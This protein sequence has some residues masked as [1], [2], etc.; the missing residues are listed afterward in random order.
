MQQ[1]NIG[2]NS[3]VFDLLNKVK[4]N[5]NKTCI[6]EIMKAY[7]QYVDNTKENIDYSKF[8]TILVNNKVIEFDKNNKDLFI[9]NN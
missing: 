6:S 4:Y 2:L 5:N 7:Y 3:I 9:L 1:N 8:L